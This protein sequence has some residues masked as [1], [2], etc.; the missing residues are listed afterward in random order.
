V[1]LIID[2]STLI[3]G[4]RNGD[5]VWDVLHRLQRSTDETVA[6]LSAVTVVE[7][8]H[9][10]YRAKVEPDKQRR[11]DFVDELCEAIPVQP[12]TLK[13]ARLAG[14]IHGEQMAKGVTIDFPDLL[15]AATALHLDFSV[16]T[17][18]TRHFRLIPGL[19]VV[20]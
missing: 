11:R 5:A 4:E 14:Q 6:V 13:I 2:S 12:I 15:I 16:A 19:K 7:L 1:G 3:A 17:L 8:T 20:S 18:N 10:I 9:G